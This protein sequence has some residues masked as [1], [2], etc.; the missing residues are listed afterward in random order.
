MFDLIYIYFNDLSQLG[1]VYSLL[2][3]HIKSLNLLLFRFN[4]TSLGDLAD[5]PSQLVFLANRT[6][7]LSQFL[8]GLRYKSS[9][10]A[11]TTIALDK[12]AV[13]LPQRRFPSLVSLGRRRYDGVYGVRS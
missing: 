6:P 3:E 10:N 13:S 4:V 5:V 8:F 11:L 12:R 9:L 2:A 7:S 1:F